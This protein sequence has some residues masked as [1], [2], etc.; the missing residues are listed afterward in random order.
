MA[1]LLSLAA[2]LTYGAADFIGGL[3]TKRNDVFR[4][5]LLSQLLG[6]IPLLVVFPMLND[7]ALTSNAI[8]WGAGAGI[9]GGGGVVLLY[10]GLS[11]GRMS[12]VAP[13][14]AV[15][16]AVVPVL[17]GLATGERPGVAALVGVATALVA[18]GFISAV[19]E[20]VAGQSEARRSGIVEA[21]GAGIAFGAFFILLD[22]VDDDAG[23][24][25]LLVMRASSI[26][27]VAVGV[28]DTRVP[29]RP[30]QG[31]FWGIAAAGT[32]DVAA[33]ILYL[34][35][36]REGLLTIVAVVTSMYPAMTVLLARLHLKERFT[37]VQVVG[38]VLAAVAIVL[39]ATG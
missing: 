1:I 23:M 20:D 5:V 9:A 7:G 4:V 11:I 33:N 22:G 17:F 37:Q 19:K 10:R 8:W 35:S 25:P 15:E 21:F 18:V 29:L 38:L 3:M 2:A 26:A 36:T 12:V 13:I 27:L 31:S 39:I 34:L 14:T 32:F 6:A 30:A 16:A 24:W 28:L